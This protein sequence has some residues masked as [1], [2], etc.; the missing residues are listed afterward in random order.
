[1]GLTLCAEPARYKTIA[2]RLKGAEP[3]GMDHHGTAGRSFIG[4][5]PF[6]D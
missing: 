5:N 4:Q 3:I 6:L 2:I 1:M